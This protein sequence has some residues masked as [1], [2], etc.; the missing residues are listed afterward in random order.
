MRFVVR[1]LITAAAVA[2]AAQIFDGIW[3]EGP[4]QG[5]AELE[6]K[7]LPL[8]L[9]SLIS[10]AVTSFVKPVLAL[11]SIPFI[12]ITLGFFLL[13]LNAL[14]LFFTEWLSGLFDL[15]FHV[16]GFWTALGGALVISVTT[17]ILD[18]LVGVDE[19]KD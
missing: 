11:L 18:A 16:E 9:V 13:V 7:W 6:E 15:G 3:F 4:K 10:W 1:L 17:W 5:Q 12:L 2:L 19:D 8:L 14:L